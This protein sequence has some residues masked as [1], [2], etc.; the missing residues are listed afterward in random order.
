MPTKI[1]GYVADEL[2]DLIDEIADYHDIPKTR[3][4]ELLLR[5]GVNNR[6]QRI[7]MEQINIKLERM[8][9][10][11]GINSN[12]EFSR[13]IAEQS[14]KIGNMPLPEGT[15]GVDLVTPHPY[16]GGDGWYHDTKTHPYN[17]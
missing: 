12:M 1:S 13:E 9:R 15:T 7:K 3:A 17:E 16:F 5:E 4:H 10:E 8:L 2:A 14:K 6:H 11:F